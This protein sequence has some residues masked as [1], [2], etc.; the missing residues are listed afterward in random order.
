[1]AGSLLAMEGVGI[2]APHVA[3]NSGHMEMRGNR[4]GQCLTGL[5]YLLATA[6]LFP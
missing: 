1:M 2:A 6:D 3:W 5:A 4:K